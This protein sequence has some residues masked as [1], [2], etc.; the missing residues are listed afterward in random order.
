MYR[1][2]NKTAAVGVITVNTT[3]VLDIYNTTHRQAEPTTTATV[4]ATTTTGA[5][6]VHYSAMYGMC[7]AA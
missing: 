7:A 3:G 5:I 4:T 1:A 2:N 6:T